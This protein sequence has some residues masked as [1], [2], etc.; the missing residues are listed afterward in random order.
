MK[1]IWN[2]T[3]VFLYPKKGRSCR[4][5]ICRDIVFSLA[6]RDFRVDDVRVNFHV[7]GTGTQRY[8]HVSDVWYGDIHIKYSFIQS[9]VEPNLND[10]AGLHS[11]LVP[12]IGNVCFYNDGSE[13]QVSPDDISRYEKALLP[14]LDNIDHTPI[15]S[16][17]DFTNSLA[18]NQQEFKRNTF[19]PYPSDYP[20][21][22]V[23]I[24]HY[25]W[26]IVERYQKGFEELEPSLRTIPFTNGWLIDGDIRIPSDLQGKLHHCS[27]R[28]TVKGFLEDEYKQVMDRYQTQ[29]KSRFFR[30][31]LLVAIRPHYLD[32]VYVRNLAPAEKY[33]QECFKTTDRLS[34][35][36]YA[37]YMT[38]QATTDNVVSMKDY[39]EKGMKFKNVQYLIM[40][41]IGYDEVISLDLVTKKDIK[42][43]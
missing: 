42:N 28:S 34:V 12:G 20:T 2:T 23:N 15:T 30:N 21:I 35:E 29:E 3:P 25:T 1:G 27:Y 32:R 8:K 17:R 41:P 13:G 10:T 22:Y 14:L 38:L 36:Q 7:Y 4:I 43:Y 40:G 31:R 18:K 9:Q 5:P 19:E 37:R 11:C 26:K 33:R 39:M 6:E 24:R 16:E